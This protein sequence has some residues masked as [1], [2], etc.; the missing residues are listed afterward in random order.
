MMYL[1]IFHFPGTLHV[2]TSKIKLPFLLVIS[3][4]HPRPPQT[5]HGEGRG[6]LTASPKR[7]KLQRSSNRPETWPGR[8]ARGA[9][10]AQEPQ[11]LRVE[12][13][14]DWV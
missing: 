1:L 3:V 10:N 12:L 8:S 14:A 9:P 4:P 5:L 2:R 6:R 13:G 11:G 7:A